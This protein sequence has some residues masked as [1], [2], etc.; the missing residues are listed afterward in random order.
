MTGRMHPADLRVQVAFTVF[1]MNHDYQADLERQLEI[2][3]QT[4]KETDL[5]LGELAKSEPTLADLC[6]RCQHNRAM[7]P[8]NVTMLQWELKEE[9]ARRERAEA[10]VKRLEEGPPIVGIKV[11]DL[12]EFKAKVAEMRERLEEAQAQ[13][14]VQDNKNACLEATL[15]ENAHLKRRN[16]ELAYL[17]K[18]LVHGFTD[19]GSIGSIGNARR[20]GWVHKDTVE[21]WSQILDGSIMPLTPAMPPVDPRL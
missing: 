1:G 2:I 14:E 13:I 20:H 18:D 21:R 8:G 3:A 9:V 17:A 6:P 10:E 15:E 12:P 4:V 5:L 16:Q 19:I 11:T 7:G